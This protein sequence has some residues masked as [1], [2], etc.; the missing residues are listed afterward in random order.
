VKEQAGWYCSF[1]IG[2]SLGDLFGFIV[3]TSASFVGVC[4]I[5]L[6]LFQGKSFSVGSTRVVQAK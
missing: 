2:S 6:F 5:S 1:C 4:S 3:T